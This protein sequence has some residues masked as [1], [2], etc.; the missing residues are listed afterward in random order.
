MDFTDELFEKVKKY[1]ND[2]IIEKYTL[3][4]PSKASENR[5]PLFLSSNFEPVL[6][7]EGDILDALKSKI[8]YLMEMQVDDSTIDYNLN[9]L[10]ARIQGTKERWI[11][12]N[13]ADGDM[14]DMELEAVENMYIFAKSDDEIF[15]ELTGSKNP[16]EYKEKLLKDLSSYSTNEDLLL[17]EYRYIQS[18]REWQIVS[19]LNNDIEYLFYKR[20]NEIISDRQFDKYEVPR[21]LVQYPMDTTNSKIPV[22]SATM[23]RAKSGDILFVDLDVNKLGDIVFKSRYDVSMFKDK[24]VSLSI[25]RLGKFDQDII[26]YLIGL[27]SEDFFRTREVITTVGD[28]AKNI[29]WSKS[30]HTYKSIRESL[31]RLQY[32]TIVAV[33]SELRG[34]SLKILDNVDI[35]PVNG[36]DTVRVLFNE[37]VV[38]Q[39]A[40]KQTM[41]LY[42][43]KV[44]SFKHHISTPILLNL[45]RERMSAFSRGRD[46]FKINYNRFNRYVYFADNKKSRNIKKILDALDEIV[47]SGMAIKEYHRDRDNFTVIFHPISAKERHDLFGGVA[48]EDLGKDI[49]EIGDMEYQ[50]TIEDVLTKE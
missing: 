31:F 30:V 15:S 3:L 19:A 5:I 29:P 1:V 16:V 42:G 35:I 38:Q 39:I 34:F 48:L 6:I 46:T 44:D 40:N 27:R 32:L 2:V 23:E 8:N 12:K 17:G 13:I 18:K 36:K 26:S 20:L 11:K 24:T 22:D 9:L 41:I 4:T 45:Q 49:I 25:N 28:I 47:E 37:D 43:D 50:L 10:R 21:E 33:N 14:L 7:N